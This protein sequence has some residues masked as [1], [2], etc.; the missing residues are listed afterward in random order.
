MTK[1][2]VL[3]GGGMLQMRETSGE[4]RLN[5]NEFSKVVST[6]RKELT[7]FGGSTAGG[8]KKLR[9]VGLAFDQL[10]KEGKNFR[11]DLLMSGISFEEQTEGMAQF[12]DIMNKTGQLRG[13]SDKQI[14]EEGAKYLMNMKAISAFTGEDAKQAQARAKQAAE[15][16][17]VRVKLE[18]LGGES[19]QKFMAL[20]AKMGPDMTKAIQQMLVTGGQVV[21]K[22]LNIMLAN[23]PTRKK[24]LDQVYADL[25]AGTISAKEASAR[26][27][28][29]V[30]DNAEA[31]KAEG[32]S[33]AET[34][35]GI[36]AL[37]KG[38]DGVTRLAEGQQDLANRGLAAREKEIA[39]LGDTTEQMK[40]L[41]KLGIDPLRESIVNAELVV[42]N[43]L[44]L[45]M[46]NLTGGI[47][48]FTDSIGDKGLAGQMK[49]QM[50]NQEKF[51]D[52]AIRFISG[53]QAEIMT[54]GSKV[55][56]GFNKVGDLL[57]T[58]VSKLSGVVKDF[59]GVVES[60]RPK[61]KF[62]KG[63]LGVEG[64]YFK[65][66]GA[67]TL[68]ELHGM[69]AVMTPAQV[70]ELLQ[71]AQAGAMKGLQ[72]VQPAQ[73]DTES[74]T[75]NQVSETVTASLTALTTQLTNTSQMQIGKLDELISTMRDKTIW[76]DML[77]AMEDNADYSKRIADNIA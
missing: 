44:P 68:V 43:Q 31:L 67:G 65:D 63:T 76:E 52:A 38:L 2:G 75:A 28:A 56:E 23:S 66:F 49:A 25:N 37:D 22:N 62:N 64:N 17:A 60:L 46:N 9:N 29:L 24:I 72:S 36:S 57:L 53:R 14:A 18:K 21:D 5:L 32:D 77:R 10:A 15:Q 26:Y 48:Q 42:R 55:A 20:S 61:L 39:Q 13:M 50:Q 33:M 35:G 51:M 74:A 19:T 41:T 34:F 3:F 59:S 45:T 58:A 27:E 73:T 30:K 6:S 4:L 12:M 7:D 1:N 71:N 54:P 8:V 70:Q 16:G 11:Q 69:E 47:A 40:N